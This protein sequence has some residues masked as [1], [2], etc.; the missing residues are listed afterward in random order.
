MFVPNPQ[1]SPVFLHVCHV[2]SKQLALVQLGIRTL[3]SAQ[4]SRSERFVVLSRMQ[5]SRVYPLRA[6]RGQRVHVSSHVREK[7]L[8]CTGS[9]P[10]VIAKV[11]SHLGYP[12]PISGECLCRS[13][14]LSLSLEAEKQTARH[15]QA[16]ID[17]ASETSRSAYTWCRSK[18]SCFVAV[19]GKGATVYSATPQ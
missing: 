15:Q 18:I 6:I 5:A 16:A 9:E 1:V 2:P 3:P 13:E 7:R 14:F 4:L 8:V 17:A 12:V 11:N 19:R 10:Y